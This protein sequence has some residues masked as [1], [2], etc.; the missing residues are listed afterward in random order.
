PR[1]ARRSDR[2]GPREAR[3]RAAQRGLASA[4]ARA[5]RRGPVRAHGRAPERRSSAAASAD[6]SSQPHAPRRSLEAGIDE[7]AAGRPGA[8]ASL[9][10]GAERAERVAGSRLLGDARQ[11]RKS[12]RRERALEQLDDREIARS[13]PDR[14]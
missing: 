9:A 5:G 13:Q 14:V 1:R 2:A 8:A 4:T 10:A 11:A 3:A 7:L 6:P 12:T